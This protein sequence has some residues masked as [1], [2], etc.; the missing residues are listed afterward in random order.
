MHRLTIVAATCLGIAACATSGSQSIAPDATAEDS[1][2]QDK[3]T[4]VMGEEKA[5]DTQ[6]AFKV[7]DTQVRNEI[8]CRMEKRTGT[9]RKKRVCRSRAQIEK[10]AQD[11]K[12]AFEVLRRTQNDQ[13]Q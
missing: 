4:T 13:Q 11:G 5:A 10:S 7:A 2:S 6:E 1:A 12:D 3:S 9:N 8:V